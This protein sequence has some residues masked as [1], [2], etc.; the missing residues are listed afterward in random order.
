MRGVLVGG[1]NYVIAAYSVTSVILV[2]Y[3]VSLFVRLT[4]DRGPRSEDRR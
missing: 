3:A 2:S 4:E 1:W